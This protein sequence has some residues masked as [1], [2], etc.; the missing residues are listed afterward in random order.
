M[1]V[2]AFGGTM[3]TLSKTNQEK[4]EHQKRKKPQRSRP[5][6]RRRHPKRNPLPRNREVRHRKIRSDQNPLDGTMCHRSHRRLQRLS[7]Q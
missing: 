6:Q 5:L 1:P 7:H 3:A 2:K 4:N